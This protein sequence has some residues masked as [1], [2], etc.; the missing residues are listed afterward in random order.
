MTFVPNTLWGQ[1]RA[2]AHVFSRFVLWG[3]EAISMAVAL[4]VAALASNPGSILATAEGLPCRAGRSPHGGANSEGDRDQHGRCVAHHADDAPGTGHIGIAPGYR[5]LR[6]RT[7]RSSSLRKKNSSN[8]PPLF[9]TPYGSSRESE[10][11]LD[12]QTIPSRVT[13]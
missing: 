2:R 7:A 1:G 4:L 5:V 11:T 8:H 12:A 6:R 10:V 9:A 13:N 3:P